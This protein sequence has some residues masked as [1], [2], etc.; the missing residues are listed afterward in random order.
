MAKKERREV[1]ENELTEEEVRKWFNRLRELYKEALSHIHEIKAERWKL[2]HERE[3]L[4]KEIRL[5]K[6]E[7]EKMKSEKERK[8]KVDFKKKFFDSL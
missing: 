2:R 5:L 3:L 7:N 8:P 1:P 4:L 6:K